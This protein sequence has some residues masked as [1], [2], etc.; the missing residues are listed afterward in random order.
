MRK[1]FEALMIMDLVFCIIVMPACAGH[2]P[3]GDITSIVP[4]I[5]TAAHGSF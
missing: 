5:V 4:F 1:V 3:M 2:D